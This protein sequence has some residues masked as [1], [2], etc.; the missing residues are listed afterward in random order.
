[1]ELP[2]DLAVAAA[3][4][5]LA[6]PS[7]TQRG[8]VFL[9]GLLESLAFE[10]PAVCA[11]L[12][13]GEE[14][15]EEEIELAASDEAVGDPEA[16]LEEENKEQDEEEADDRFEVEDRG[17]VAPPSSASSVQ[18]FALEPEKKNE[19]EDQEAAETTLRLSWSSTH[20]KDDQGDKDQDTTADLDHTKTA[21][22]EPEPVASNHKQSLVPW[23][24][25]VTEDGLHRI[26]RNTVI[27]RG[28]HA[29]RHPWS[30]VV[31]VFAVALALAGIGLL[32]NFTLLLDHE[33]IF[34]PIN[35]PPAKHGQW[36]LEESGFT[37]TDNM[38]LIVHAD[39]KDVLNV[40]AIHR[41]FEA[42][43]TLQNVPGYDDVCAHAGHIDPQTEQH[44]CWIWSVTQ[45]WDHNVTKF[46][47]Q[48][49]TELELMDALSQPAFPDGIP[50]FHEYVF[51]CRYYISFCASYA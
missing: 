29:A 16:G 3:T 25:C 50:V 21:G 39:G 17:Q 9:H 42:L 4:E 46:E 31:G 32:T 8:S 23:W 2:Q 40:P 20:S 35:S 49:H 13:D 14:E 12:G 6:D 37:E 38:L 41:V 34:T 24:T 26:I 44:T 5:E 19:E 18:D 48:A 43:T 27:Q 30:Y 15:Q 10:T 28:T 47:E 33:Q 36:L 22:P 7:W 45:F 51:Y 11:T 1:M